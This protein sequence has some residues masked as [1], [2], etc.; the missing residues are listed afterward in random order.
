M[1]FMFSH[2]AKLR[3][4][5]DTTDR[6]DGLP[7]INRNLPL[8]RLGTDTLCLH[9][10]PAAMGFWLFVGL[11]VAAGYNDTYANVNV[12]EPRGLA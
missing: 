11:S 2:T 6:G 12:D 4:G 9:H 3:P 7:P 5:L 8:E 1:H 10:P